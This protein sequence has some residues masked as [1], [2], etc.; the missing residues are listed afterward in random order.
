MGVSDSAALRVVIFSIAMGICD[1]VA[2]RSSQDAGGTAVWCP[3]TR[4][5]YRTH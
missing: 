4:R 2:D 5:T 3:N 1:D